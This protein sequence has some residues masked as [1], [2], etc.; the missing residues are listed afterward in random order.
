M[1]QEA[2]QSPSIFVH[3]GTEMDQVAQLLPADVG[4]ETYTQRG[5]TAH[6]V[7]SY[8]QS[9]GAESPTLADAVLAT[10]EADYTRLQEWFGNITIGNLPFYVY[11]RP[12]ANG[13]SHADCSATGLYCDA[14]N[15]TDA[16]LERSLVVAEADEVFMANQGA[17][18]DCGASNGEALSRLLAA[19]IYPNELNPPGIGGTFATG[20][21]WLRSNRPDWITS[22]EPT[23]QDFVSIGCGTL[24][25]NWLHFQLGYSLNQIVQAGRTTLAQTY[26]TLTGRSDAWGRFI[27]LLDQ[28]F[29]AGQDLGL[30]NDNPFPLKL[31]GSLRQFL[32]AHGADLSQGVRTFMQLYQPGISNLRYLC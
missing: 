21:S 32:V 29:P 9:L 8:A 12:G 28:H 2:S 23:D 20:P 16:D 5:T 6:F 24:F 26:N 13:A 15:G 17:G 11:I 22:T 4:D 27:A 31:T 7:V 19:E 10:C 1:I 25:I 30:T 18:W 14:F 3:S